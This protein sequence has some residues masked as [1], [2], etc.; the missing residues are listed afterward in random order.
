MVGYTGGGGLWSGKAKGTERREK[1]HWA[2][3]PLWESSFWEM[4][5]RV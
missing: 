3:I 4:R 1:G 5:G 2:R